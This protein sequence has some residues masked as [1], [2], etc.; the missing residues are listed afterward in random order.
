[1]FTLMSSLIL[2]LLENLRL[3]GLKPESDWELEYDTTL[4]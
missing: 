1:M 2:L 3:V 4:K